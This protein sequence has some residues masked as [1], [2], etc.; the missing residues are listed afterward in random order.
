MHSNKEGSLVLGAYCFPKWYLNRS[1]EDSHSERMAYSYNS[2]SS[3]QLFGLSGLLLKVHQGFSQSYSTTSL[4]DRK[5]QE[6]CWTESC[7]EAFVSLKD[8]L[9]SAPVLVYPEI[10]KVF[11]LDWDTSDVAI[12]GV[13]LQ[14]KD[15][16]E[17]FIAYDSK[18]LTKAERRYCVTRRELFAIVYF[19]K[20]FKQ[21][22]YDVKFLVRTDH[23]SLCWLFNFKEPEGQVARWIET[24][25]TYQFEVQHHPGKQHSNADALSRIPC[26]QCGRVDHRDIQTVLVKENTREIEAEPEQSSWIT[27]WTFNF[28]REEQLKDSTISKILQMKQTSEQRPPWN[29]ISA[30]GQSV[31][32]YWFL[33]KQL[34]IKSGVL[35]KLRES[36]KPGKSVWQLVLPLSLRKEVLGQL[37]DHI[38][39]GHFGQHTTVAKVRQR[40]YWHG[41]M[42]YV[43]DWCH[44]FDSCATIK[45]TKKPRAPLQ[46]F[47]VGCPLERVAMDILGPLPRSHNGNKYILVVADCFTKWTEAYAIPNQEATTIVKTLVVKFICRYGAPMQIL[48]DQG[49]QFESLLFTEICTLLD[50]DKTRTGSFHPQTNDLV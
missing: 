10:G 23:G 11:V 5:G 32:T 35:Y 38:T 8:K 13:L 17:H 14:M 41:L 9:T 7:S 18:S 43:H 29:D 30:E 24:L 49:R 39:A 27:G 45:L 42:E 28:L 19:V 36:E 37:H 22:L 46:Q 44:Q 33:W 25:S 48:T 16:K 4:I 6:V 12:E 26:K 40:F 20:H 21:Y 47:P 3:G 1:R 34:H 15:D 2:D 50:I 31:K